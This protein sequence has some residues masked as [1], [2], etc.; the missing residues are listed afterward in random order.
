MCVCVCV[1][2]QSQCIK[3]NNEN[4]SKFVNLELT[5]D[6]KL[7]SCYLLRLDTY[8]LLLLKLQL[9]SPLWEGETSS[10]WQR[11][12][13]FVRSMVTGPKVRDLVP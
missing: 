1:C 11:S 5:F 4:W 10:G 7:Q 13:R 2:V 12:Y 3:P 6:H 8:H 9:H